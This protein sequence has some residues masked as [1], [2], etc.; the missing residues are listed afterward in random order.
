MSPVKNRLTRFSDRVVNYINFRPGYPDSV[1]A[2]LKSEFQLTDESLVADIGSGTG[3][4]SDVF[5]NGGFRVVG[6]EPN[7]EMREAG[8]RLL[9]HWQTFESREGTAEKTGL[10]DQSVDLIVAGQA[11]HWFDQEQ[12]KKEFRRIVKST[13]GVAL[14]WN[15]RR[16]KEPFLAHYEDFLGEHANDYGTV[17]HRRI[18][19]DVF[20][21]FFSP[22]G[23][24]VSERANSQMFDFDGLLGRYLSSSYSYKEDDSRF[25]EAKSKLK[26]LFDRFEIDGRI[27]FE[28]DTRT[29]FGRL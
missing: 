22:N 7:F 14:V 5:L 11:F 26:A 18:D 15:E 19:N 16:E 20:K 1:V 4:L 23:Y 10:G 6:I 13:G 21:R 29:Y 24:S 12:C 8:E 9:S 28:Y 17:K 3:K 25:P 2:H 27:R